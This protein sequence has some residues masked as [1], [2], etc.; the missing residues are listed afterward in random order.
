MRMADS[1]LAAFRSG[2]FSS[3]ISRTCWRVTLPTLSRFGA[4]DP[5]SRPAAFFNSTGAGGVLVT[6]VNERSLYTVISTGMIIPAWLCVRAL[7]CLQ[8]SMMFTPCWPSAG[9][10]GGAGFAA[11]AGTWSLMKPTTFFAMRLISLELRVV[12]LDRG[13]SAEQAHLYLDLP[14]V[15]VDVLHRSAEVRERTLGD[16]HNL[17]D[18]ERDLLAGFRL[19]RLGRESEDLVDL[20]LT[21]RLRLLARPDELDDALDVVDDVL[22]PL[23]HH[24]LHQH[25]ARVEPP[26]DGHPLAVLDL[27]DILRR[28][29]RLLDLLLFRG[30][31]RLLG[32]PVV[33]QLLDLVLV[34]R[35]RLDRVPAHLFRH[36][37][38]REEVDDQIQDPADGQVHPPD[39]EGND[40]HEDEDDEGRVLELWPVRPRHLLQFVDDFC[41]EGARAGQ[42]NHSITPQSARTRESGGRQDARPPRITSFPC[43][44]CASCT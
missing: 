17:P 20:L 24:H 40:Q 41:A 33:D 39:D 28:D 11:P 10:T 14:L 44:P 36:G 4:A 27:D 22:G 8:N 25:V 26:R 3:A 15:G 5:F 43:A 31:A 19:L 35:V 38:T 42:R 6:N 21:Q 9:P 1:M 12:Q 30:L 7:N 32:D 18:P 29:D 23:V 2:I 37:S 34:T 16:L 13:R